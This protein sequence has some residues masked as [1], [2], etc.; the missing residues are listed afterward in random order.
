VLFGTQCTPEHP[1]GA[2]MVS[3]EGACAAHFQYA[4]TPALAGT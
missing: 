4:L 2:L 3:S 1:I